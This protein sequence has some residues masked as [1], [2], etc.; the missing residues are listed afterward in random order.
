MAKQCRSC[1]DRATCMGDYQYCDNCTYVKYGQASLNY[2]NRCRSIDCAA[3]ESNE[4]SKK[5][6]KFRWLQPGDC[7]YHITSDGWVNIHQTCA[8]CCTRADM[9]IKQRRRSLDSEIVQQ[10][11]QIQ[12]LKRKLQARDQDQAQDQ[13]VRRVKRTRYF[14]NENLTV[15]ITNTVP[16]QQKPDPDVILMFPWNIGY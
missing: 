8:V 10:K 15:T 1:L 11:K 13:M 4:L 16:E 6:Q 2:S 14:D 5:Y 3:L 9:Q 12:S 7:I